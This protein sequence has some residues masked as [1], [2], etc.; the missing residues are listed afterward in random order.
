MRELTRYE[1]GAMWLY[2]NEYAEGGLGAIEFWK[3]LGKYEKNTVRRMVK[4]IVEAKEK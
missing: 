2:H 1:R 3:K 4:D